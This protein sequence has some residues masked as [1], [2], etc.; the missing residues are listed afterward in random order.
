[1]GVRFYGN[2]ILPTIIIGK[3]RG[4]F[5]T[6]YLISANED[7]SF[8]RQSISNGS[9]TWSDTLSEAST[10]VAIDGNAYTNYSYIAYQ[11][12]NIKKFDVRGSVVW[13]NTLLYIPTD[14]A[15]GSNN[16]IYVVQN[17]N[18]VSIFDTESGEKDKDITIQNASKV[19][20]KYGVHVGCTNG[21]VHYIDQDGI[22]QGSYNTG[23]SI[24]DI[25]NNKDGSAIALSSNKVS[26]IS[27]TYS[28]VWSYNDT[29]YGNFKSFT[30]DPFDKVTYIGTTSGNIIKLND[31]G[32]YINH[33]NVS[34]NSMNAISFWYDTLYVADSTGKVIAFDESFSEKWSRDGATS[35][36]VDIHVTQSQE[37]IHPP[38]KT[39]NK[40][41]LSNVVVSPQVNS[42]VTIS[43][44]YSEN[45]YANNLYKSEV[46]VSKDLLVTSK[47]VSNESYTVG[48]NY[49][50][51]TSVYNDYISISPTDVS[52]D[53]VTLS[54]PLVN[55]SYTV[56]TNFNSNVQDY[57][58][59]VI[60]PMVDINNDK[61]FNTK[62]VINQSY[63]LN[64]N[65]TGE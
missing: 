29:S 4:R 19:A 7:G 15:L 1:M 26:K 45:D 57:N 6:I 24:I 47:P 16:K 60:A 33:I 31:S 23:N 13:E 50:D 14:L 48:I 25:N 62:P 18:T 12:K 55:S 54:K 51:Q 3:G 41:T 61:S 21:Y 17:S 39:I 30:Y 5:A 40:G 36:K 65:Y 34:S 38:I 8:Y 43:A 52:K 56:D 35:S 32:Q 58:D 44:D 46:D 63:E 9:I 49:T 53:I 27:N 10:P 11:N 2:V 37:S 59:T 28:L 20:A 42:S 22:V 64:I